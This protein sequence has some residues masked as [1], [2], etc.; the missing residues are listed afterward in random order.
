MALLIESGATGR[1]WER[2]GAKIRAV[3]VGHVQKLEQGVRASRQR[4]VTGVRS[5]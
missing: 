5:E 3:G 1:A 4:S 2:A